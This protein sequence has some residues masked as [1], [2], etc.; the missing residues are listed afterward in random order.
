M[1]FDRLIDTWLR[2]V[3]LDI[4]SLVGLK[5]IMIAARRKDKSNEWM[6]WI[7]SVDW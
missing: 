1:T 5:K 6:N 3:V 4:L 7:Q 2:P